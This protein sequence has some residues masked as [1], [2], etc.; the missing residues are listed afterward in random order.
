M[1]RKGRGIEKGQNEKITL[2]LKPVPLSSIMT[3]RQTARLFLSYTNIH[4]RGDGT[5]QL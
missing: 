4:I 3:S 1:V 2:S 5:Q